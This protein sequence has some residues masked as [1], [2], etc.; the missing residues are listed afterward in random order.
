MAFWRG[1]SCVVLG[2]GGQ[3]GMMKKVAVKCVVV[4]LGPEW[5]VS[6]RRVALRLHHFVVS[7][8]FFL[9]LVFRSVDEIRWDST[10]GWK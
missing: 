1:G 9:C 10:S 2:C 8:L 3:D 5:S 4:L 6:L 7:L